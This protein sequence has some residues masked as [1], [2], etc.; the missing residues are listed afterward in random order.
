[1]LEHLTPEL[2]ISGLRLLMEGYKFGRDQFKDKKT[3]ERVE[4]ILTRAEQE[5]S[6]D[7]KQIEDRLTEKLEPADAAIVKNDLQLLSLLLVP[8]PSLDAFDYWGKLTQLVAGLGTFANKN[9]LFELRGVNDSRSGEAIFLPKTSK[10]LLPKDFV[11]G[12]A[13]PYSRQRVAKIDCMVILKK[14]VQ[15]FPLRVIVGAEFT[16]YSSF[17]TDSSVSD[18]CIYELGPGQQ[19]HW[20]RVYR[21]ASHTHF[22]PQ[23]EYRLKAV[24]F[25]AIANAL[26]DDLTD[27]AEE[28]QTDEQQIAPLFAQIETFAE[29]MKS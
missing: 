5:G 23:D 12:L 26:R 8:V 28:V 18:S 17:G 24:N 20:L 22:V 19:R 29:K 13:A 3:P 10:V 15:D 14:Q 4:E 25:I 1:M 7:R 11:F 16:E 27:C 9:R 6:V 2:I 21:P